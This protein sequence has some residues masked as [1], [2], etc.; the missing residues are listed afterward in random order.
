MSAPDYLL[1]LED[2]ADTIRVNVPALEQRVAVDPP[3]MA[4]QEL[5]CWL[6]YG[7]IPEN[8]WGGS[9]D[10]CQH[11]IQIIV[12]VPNNGTSYASRA[13]SVNTTTVAVREAVKRNVV[14]ADGADGAVMA[15]GITTTG[16][17]GYKYEGGD[18]VS[19]SLTLTVE[20]KAFLE[21]IE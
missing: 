20:T 2:L 12:A 13:R 10:V 4:P 14:L 15:R 7:G 8:Q 6:V 1:M 3:D 19:A 9:L 16:A 21:V 5:S 11:A 18:I 17:A